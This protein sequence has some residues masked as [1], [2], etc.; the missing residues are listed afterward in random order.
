MKPPFTTDQFLDVFARYNVAV[1]PVQLFVYLLGVLCIVLALR[2]ATYSSRIISLI[3]SLFWLWM[4]V[5]YHFLFFSKINQAAW[6]F[7]ALLIL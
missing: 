7:G 2:R 6:M 4:G 5:V 3:L 1:W